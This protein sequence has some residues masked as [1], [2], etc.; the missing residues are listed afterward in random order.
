MKI[1]IAIYLIFTIFY[2]VIWSFLVTDLLLYFIRVG[3][4]AIRD[5]ANKGNPNNDDN[6]DSKPD[7]YEKD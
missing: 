2:L 6:T 4:Q 5:W 1:F 3:Q 7:N